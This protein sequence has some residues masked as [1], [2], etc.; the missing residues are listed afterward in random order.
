MESNLYKHRFVWTVLLLVL[1]SLIFGCGDKKAA[2]PSTVAVTVGKVETRTMPI[3][4]DAVGN[5]QAY[6]SA[7][8]T[9]L[10]TGRVLQLHFQQG[11]DIKAGDLLITI[12]PEPFEQ[13]L[14]QAKAQLTHDRNQAAFNQATAKRYDYL[15]HND[16]VSRQDYEQMA[17]AASTENAT[18]AQSEAA[19]ENARINLN[20][21]YIRSP[22]N[23]RTGAILANIGTLATANQTQLVVVNQITP[24]FVQF[25]IPEKYL[26]AVTAA[27]KNGP[28]PVMANISDQGMRVTDG[29]LT[30][31]DNTVDTTS[32]VI[33]MKAQFPN[34]NRQL[35]PGQFVRITVKLGEQSNAVVVPDAAIMDGQ[36]GKY[37]FIVK[38]D[39]TVEV[40]PVTVDRVFDGLAVVTKGLDPGET[41]VTDGQVN[42]RPGAKVSVKQAVAGNAQS[43]AQ[44]GGA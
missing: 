41:V 30:F 12:D 40:R 13:Q 33:Q 35:W 44:G 7:A 39:L 28:L 20:N 18:V 14:A 27:Q 34:T 16:A 3:Q 26:A 15:L 36:Q 37:V 23:G 43:I 4:L 9:P 32:G 24:I 22:I 2:S 42:L 25:S 19:V 8:I 38:D 11:Q 29:V 1:S 10:V 5:V 21:C 17:T 6:N 31:I